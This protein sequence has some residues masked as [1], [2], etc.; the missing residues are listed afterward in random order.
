MN[1][2]ILE[3]ERLLT[4]REAYGYL[5]VSRSTLLRLVQREEIQAYKVGKLLRFY[6][7]DLKM[8]VKPKELILEANRARVWEEPLDIESN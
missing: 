2:K 5:K 7:K 1:E 8:A 4:L 6:E 3:G